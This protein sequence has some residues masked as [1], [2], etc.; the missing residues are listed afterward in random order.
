MWCDCK[1]DSLRDV[2]QV[3]PFGFVDLVRANQTSTID[4]PI[5]VAEEKFNGIE[6]PRAVGMRPSDDFEL[7][8]GNA[9]ILAYKPKNEAESP[10]S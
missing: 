7:M 10:A 6:D 9:A 4:T 8:Q 3:E 1:Y 5:D 2:Q